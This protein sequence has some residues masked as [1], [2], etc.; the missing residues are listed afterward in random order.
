MKL[1]AYRQL[2]DEGYGPVTSFL[3]SSR[4]VLLALYVMT[5]VLG[6]IIVGDYVFGALQ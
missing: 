2:R 5:V 3:L 6:A 4:Y 1:P